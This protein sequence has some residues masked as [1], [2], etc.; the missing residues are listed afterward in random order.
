[1]SLLKQI[2]QIEL[3]IRLLA[4]KLE[5]AEAERKVLL[6]ENKQLKI[7]LSESKNAIDVLTKKL[8]TTQ[9]ILAEERAEGSE[10]KKMLKRQIEQY[11]EE[12]D[13]CIEWL[14]KI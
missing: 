10:R 7:D 6:V 14:H 5:Q 3:K 4:N 2:E 9:H 11:I 12:I 8:E 13:K 1:M